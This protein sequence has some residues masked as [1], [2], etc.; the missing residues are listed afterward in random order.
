MAFSDV[1]TSDYFYTAVQYLFCEGAVS[2]YANGTFRPYNNTTRGQLSKIVVLAEGWPINTYGGPHFQDVSPTNAFYPYIETAYNLNV[3]SGYE[4]GTGCLKFRP[5]SD[6]TRAQLTKVIVLAE[7]W[8]LQTP[9]QPTFTDVPAGDSFYAYVE[10]AYAH[11]IITGYSCGTGCLEFRPTNSA[12]RVQICT[13]IYN[14]MYVG[15]RR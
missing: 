13:I 9:A 14:A 11:N 12:T 8:A 5:N 2:G 3:I 1:H 4:C 10:T 15:R 7:A 6:I